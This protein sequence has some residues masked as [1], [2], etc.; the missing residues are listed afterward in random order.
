[1][2]HRSGIPRDLVLSPQLFSGTIDMEAPI[3]F[4]HYNDT[5]YLK[6]T[7]QGREKLFNPDKRVILLGDSSNSKVYRRWYRTSLFCRLCRFAKDKDLL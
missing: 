7:P 2:T 1:M 3:I 6:Y 4:V 5:P